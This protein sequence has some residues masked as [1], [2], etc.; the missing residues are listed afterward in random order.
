VDGAHLERLRALRA[1]PSRD[2]AGDAARLHRVELTRAEMAGQGAAIDAT[3]AGA[4]PALDEIAARLRDRAIGSVVVA[5]CGDSWFVGMGVRHALERLLGVPVVPA[6]ALDH[7]L[8]DHMGTGPGTLAIGLSAGGDTPAVMAALR[9]ARAHGAFAIGVSNAEA[10]PIQTAF[11]AGLRVR[12]TRKGW[13]TQSSAAA[14][15]LLIAFGL[16]LAREP[17]AAF[18]TEFAGI[19]TVADATL[20]ACDDAMA[21]IARDLARAGTLFFAG[22]GPHGAT[23]QFA[24]AKIR[25][26]APIHAACF[27]LEELHHYRLPKAGD[28]IFVVAPDEASRPRALDTALVGKAVGARV[29]VALSRP[30]P[31]IEALAAGIVRL[32][33]CD[34]AL[35]PIAHAPAFHALAYHFARAR[36]AAGLDYGGVWDG[37]RP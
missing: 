24:A 14:M 23:A 13:P 37:A 20:A 18:A 22:A 12:A 1:E 15:A 19:G 36:D 17:H 26:L 35:A 21:A 3:L 8:Y 4:A 30:D 6:Q 25:E 29:H 5:G 28:P 7:A 10:A 27:A 34:P 11:D 16:R 33:A 2:E 9:A 31:E 32:P